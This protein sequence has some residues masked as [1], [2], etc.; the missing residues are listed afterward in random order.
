MASPDDAVAREIV[1]LE[2]LE[3]FTASNS[4]G[5]TLTY[6]DTSTGVTA[7]MGAAQG[8]HTEVVRELLHK[9]ADANATD[10]DGETALMRAAWKGHTEVVRELL[11]KGADANA[12]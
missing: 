4:A 2:R 10:D 6:L 3:E 9:G 7:L 8:G 1:G 12:A 5:S 11:Q